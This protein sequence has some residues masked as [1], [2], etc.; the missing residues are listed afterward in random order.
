MTG[1]DESSDT[2]SLMSDR[3]QALDSDWWVK[4]ADSETCESQSVEHEVERLLALKSYSFLLENESLSKDLDETLCRLTSIASRSFNC[5]LA[6]VALVDLERALVIKA[7]L[8]LPTEL[9]RT[10]TPCGHSILEKSGLLVVRDL[11]KDDR[12][13]HFEIVSLRGFRFYAGAAIVSP[14]G[15]HLGSFS[16]M[17]LSPRPEGLSPDQQQTLRDMANLT[18]D[19]FTQHKNS[20]EVRQQLQEASRQLACAS[21]DL[22]T[23]LS[24]LQLS[25]SL[26]RGDKAFQ[27]RLSDQQ[28]EYL[29][30]IDTCADAMGSVCESLRMRGR[31]NLTSAPRPLNERD[32]ASDHL[33]DGVQVWDTVDFVDKIQQGL[34]VIPAN[35]A[36]AISLDPSVPA[37]LAAREVELFR[38]A[39][40]LMTQACEQAASGS[41]CLAMSLKEP[42]SESGR[43]DLLF[44][45]TVGR[46][47]KNPR[48]MQSDDEKSLRQIDWYSCLDSFPQE[49]EQLGGRYGSY[50][51]SGESSTFWFAVP[52][53]VPSESASVPLENRRAPSLQSCAVARIASRTLSQSSLD[54]GAMVVK[55]SRVDPVPLLDSFVAPVAV[56]VAK[57]KRALVVEDSLV[58]R[59]VVSRALARLDFEVEQAANGMEGLQKMEGSRFDLVLCD[60]LMPVMDGL[61]CVREYRH[62]E[63]KHRPNFRQYIVGMSAH[64]SVNDTDRGRSMG[65][66]DFLPKPVNLEDLNRLKLKMIGLSRCSSSD[67]T[68]RSSPSRTPS[69][70]HVNA[71]FQD[72]LRVC[73]VATDDERSRKQVSDAAFHSGWTCVLAENGPQALSLLKTRNWGAAFVDAELKGLGGLECVNRFRDWEA[74]NRIHR[75]SSL[76]LLTDL[77]EVAGRSD[78]VSFVQVPEGVDGAMPRPPATEQLDC[79][80]QHLEGQS[81]VFGPADII[82][83]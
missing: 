66:D 74:E 52:V 75:Q 78:S 41:I 1:N 53:I 79:L 57:A 34:S 47:A 23:P 14:E 56:S 37:K 50:A 51:R 71:N 49:V 48:E 5:C 61:D 2:S 76:F 19:T 67:A 25:V 16:I 44:E 54:L 73:L 39:Y 70:S 55:R 22:A 36:V 69:L 81:R 60:F 65:M 6:L 11:S 77:G 20:L 68:L 17:D 58:V 21:H 15:Y 83:T 63:S 31:T 46:L 80:F 40:K 3:Q 26:L 42:S 13:K 7:T 29:S 33:L 28:K 24:A 30:T 8:D 4:D 62:W 12:F 72:S 64:A 38:L 45:C 9:K 43:P 32:V 10:T 82:T 18:A 59:K 27:E 35:G